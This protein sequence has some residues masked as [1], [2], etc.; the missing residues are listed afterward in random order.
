VVVELGGTHTRGQTVV[1]HVGFGRRAPNVD[2]VLA[3]D[4]DRFVEMLH[5]TLAP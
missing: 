3:A 1:D 5:L 4:R 2:V